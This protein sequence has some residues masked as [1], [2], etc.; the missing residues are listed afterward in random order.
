[1]QQDYYEKVKFLKLVF[2]ALI[3]DMR[4]PLSGI[5]GFIQLIEQKS[6]D[7]AIKGYCDTVLNSIKKLQQINNE[8][9]DVIDGKK[10]ELDKS[11]ISLF[12]LLDEINRRLIETYQYANVTLSLKVDKKITILGDEEKLIE[13]FTKILD[14]SKE[15]MPEGGKIKVKV[16]Q[17]DFDA[18][19]E[20][21]DTG[22]G[23]PAHIQ[24]SIFMPFITYDK[25]EAIG[26]GLTYSQNIIKG[27]GGSILVTS[28]VGKGSK[29]SINIP[30]AL[31]EA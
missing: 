21:N 12:S 3:H 28:Q 7:E 25:E 6:D 4:N 26:L 20:I 9:L 23:I 19:I 15:A 1:M 24:E 17:D 2:S 5:S 16:T 29:F 27:H 31:K 18:K 22:K 8:F 13:A 30:L 11:R 10:I 14:N